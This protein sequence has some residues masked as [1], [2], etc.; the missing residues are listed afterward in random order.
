MIKKLKKKFLLTNLKEIS[1]I[2]FF[3]L[4]N[5][6]NL[7]RKSLKP[8]N[9]ILKSFNLKFGKNTIVYSVTTEYQGTSTLEAY[10]YLWKN[11]TKIVISDI[12]GTITK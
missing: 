9:N 6:K 4:S 10:I 8:N 3:L 12:D 11:N 5:L 2:Y 7:L 1:G